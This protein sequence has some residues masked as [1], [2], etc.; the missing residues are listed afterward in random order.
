MKNL[1]ESIYNKLIEKEK[2][3]NPKDHTTLSFEDMQAAVQKATSIKKVADDKK[4]A[5]NIPGDEYRKLPSVSDKFQIIVPMSTRASCVYGAGTKW[6]TAAAKEDENMFK[7]YYNRWGMTL[8]YVLPKKVNP[9]WKVDADAEN[10]AASTKKTSLTSSQ[11]AKS[12]TYKR[13]IQNGTSVLSKILQAKTNIL[14]G[15]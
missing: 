11:K 1:E 12:K 9:D 13:N 8:Y 3:P 14:N 15:W 7:R 4:L 6:C 5:K 10:K 2:K